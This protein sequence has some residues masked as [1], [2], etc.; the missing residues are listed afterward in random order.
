[1]NIEKLSQIQ[2]I[3]HRLPH[4]MTSYIYWLRDNV[5]DIKQKLRNRFTDLRR[6]ATEGAG[7]LKLP[8]QVAFLTL[9]LELVT[10]WLIDKGI[11]TEDDGRVFVSEGWDIFKCLTERH[12]ERIKDEDAVKKFEDIIHT[13]LR[14]DKITL[15]YF[16]GR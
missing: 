15:N 4:A 11:F 10:S 12:G 6:K 14:M 16:E 3:A 13:L 8:E 5:D 7:H 2:S 9:T 1:M